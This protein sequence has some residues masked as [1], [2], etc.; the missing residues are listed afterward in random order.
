MNVSIIDNTYEALIE[1]IEQAEKLASKPN[2]T[3]AE[4]R[5]HATLLAKVSAM[6][7]GVDPQ[8]LM[9]ARA[10]ALRR[11]LGFKDDAPVAK[12]SDEQREAFRE[13]VRTGKVVEFRTD[14]QNNAMWGRPSGASYT[15]GDLVSALT[16]GKAGGYTTAPEFLAQAATTNLASV[17]EIVDPRFSNY[18]FTETGNVAPVPV[19]DD[20]TG[21][22]AA[23]VKSK[24]VG[25]AVQDSQGTSLIGAAASSTIFGKAYK[26]QSALPVAMELEQ[27]AAA[28]LAVL[29]PLV[30]QQR[31]AL[32]LGD[33]FINGNGVGAPLGLATVAATLTGG[34]VSTSASS[35][36]SGLTLKEIEASYR[37]IPMPYRRRAVLYCHSDVWLQILELLETSGRANVGDAQQIFRRPIAICDSLHSPSAGNLA[38]VWAVP[39][40]L[41]QRRVRQGGIGIERSIETAGYVEQG[42][43]LVKSYVRADFLPVLY[44]SNAAPYVAL[45]LHN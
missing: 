1:T 44:A 9:V 22:P 31:H 33:A 25:D 14:D 26:Y 20:M 4:V 41:L 2:M 16:S 28:V 19:I 23:F 32:A 12:I 18:I 11:E 3:P 40:L 34:N 36:L 15:G 30:F 21:S 29:L 8:T 43:V 37:A 17:D 6:K 42:L 10:N 27:D 7:L 35:S 39:E 45:Y 38:A 13:F 24:L 5:M